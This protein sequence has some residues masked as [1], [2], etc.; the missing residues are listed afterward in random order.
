M[1][2]LVLLA[3]LA[4]G[5]S[6]G[7]SGQVQTLPDCII[8]FAFNSD[9]QRSSVT[10]CGRNL[11]G[12]IDWRVAYFVTGFSAVSVA[13]QSAPD[14]GGT[15]GSWTNFGGTIISGTNPSTATPQASILA[16]GYFPWVSVTLASST[17]SGLV[18]GVLYGCREPGCGN[19]TVT[20]QEPVTVEGCVAAGMLQTCFPLPG[21]GV[22]GTGL[23]RYIRTNTLGNQQVIGP[24]TTGEIINA[25]DNPVII[26]VASP[27]ARAR[28]L[29]APAAVSDG[30][31]GVQSASTA[32]VIFNGSTWDREFVCNQ[33]A[34]FNLTAM[35]NTQII[36]LSG[37]TVIRI[38]KIFFAADA[39][40]NI[41]VN[42][43]TG[44]NCGTGT[45]A[46]TGTFMDTKTA[47]LDFGVEAALR[48]T[49]GT[50][51]CIQLAAAV[52]LG[53]VV[54]YAQY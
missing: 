8:G 10:G 1:H 44:A 52:N 13:L 51:V 19:L 26:G 3:L 16:S 49:A 36:P 4:S 17:G 23:A 42:R 37:S 29:F 47:A 48:S 31:T 35:G 38:C 50:A 6:F 21:G 30:D 46:I 41:T 20:I 53:G 45:T 11:T 27:G 28:Q 18:T 14:A 32:K 33:Q 43:G 15:P 5:V 25:A 2:K 12:V 54:V 22:D 39:A 7:Q 34:N 9:G 24:T 40:T